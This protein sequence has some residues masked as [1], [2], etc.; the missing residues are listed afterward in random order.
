MKRELSSSDV[1][2]GQVYRNN[3]VVS[4]PPAA[5]SL[6]AV[7]E[8]EETVAQIV[9]GSD[10]RLCSTGRNLYDQLSITLK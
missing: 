3:R 2:T 8:G 4:L 10:V 1:G 9:I 7:V 6:M 5:P